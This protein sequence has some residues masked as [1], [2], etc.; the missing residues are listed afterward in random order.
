[1]VNIIEKPNID[2][3]NK[4]ERNID[5]CKVRLFFSLYPNE[6]IKRLMLDNL[7]LSFDRKMQGGSR[8][9]M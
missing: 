6:K 2:T 5:G 1:M 9:Q 7:M 3:E 4:I 8:V